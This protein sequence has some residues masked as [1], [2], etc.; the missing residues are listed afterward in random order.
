[1]GDLYERS[2][3]LLGID[4]GMSLPTMRIPSG[5]K[6][7]VARVREDTPVSQMEVDLAISVLEALMK[8]YSPVNYNGF[9]KMREDMLGTQD[10]DNI[11]WGD[12]TIN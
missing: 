1:M 10:I 7:T 3:L 11:P 6:D 9:I 8:K 2:V 5:V 12:G 4:C